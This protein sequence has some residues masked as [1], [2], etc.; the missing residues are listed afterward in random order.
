MAEMSSAAIQFAIEDAKSDILELAKLLCQ[1][2]YPRRGTSEQTQDIYEF[3]EKVQA[4]ISHEDAVE[5]NG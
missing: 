1:A 3:A 4:L 5:L 2:G